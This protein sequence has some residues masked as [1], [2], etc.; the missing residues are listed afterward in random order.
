MTLRGIF[1][2]ALSFSLSACSLYQSDG[3]KE[4]EKNAVGLATAQAYIT[5]CEWGLPSKEYLRVSSNEDAVVYASERE[6]FSMAVVPS[7]APYSCNYRFHSAQEM[8]ELTDSAIEITLQN[9][10][11]A[12]RPGAFAF[13]TDSPLK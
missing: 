1:I 10:S 8:I 9:Y 4:L 12:Q 2:L 13:P 3:R 5:G 11:M 7:E 6:D